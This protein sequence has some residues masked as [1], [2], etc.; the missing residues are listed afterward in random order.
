MEEIL[1][2]LVD[3]ELLTEST[4]EEVLA[5][6][7]EAI[8][9]QVTERTA[10]AVEVKKAELEESFKSDF[11]SERTKMTR[12]VNKFLKDNIK[13]ALEESV[14]EE[15]KTAFE[16]ERTQLIESVSAFLDLKLVEL[17]PLTESKSEATA[18]AFYEAARSLMLGEQDVPEAAETVIKSLQESLHKKELKINGLFKKLVESRKKEES[19]EL[20]S[21]VEDFVRMLPADKKTIGRRLVES[22]SLLDFDARVKQITPELLESE[23][24]TDE[25]DTP[26]GKEVVVESTK[27]PEDQPDF[28]ADRIRKLSG[29]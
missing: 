24:S 25:N 13:G 20:E 6:L 2:K 8:E 10:T 28:E 16:A 29:I 22:T 12:T 17:V 15:Y 5:Q 1:K 27:E 23:S 3:S 7:N 18:V 9:A 21:K 19:A 11:K 26:S 14:R 4:K